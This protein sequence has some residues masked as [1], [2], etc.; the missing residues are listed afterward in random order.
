M[1][2]KSLIKLLIAVF[3]LILFVACKECPEKDTTERS[4]HLYELTIDNL[5]KQNDNLKKEIDSLVRQPE[6][7]K[8]KYI[9]VY[10]K[11]SFDT[12]TVAFTP[13]S[14]CQGYP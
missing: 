3:A 1:K 12:G 7:I 6:I 2:D 4:N 9:K 13:D 8:L 5:A 10:E 11:N 14:F